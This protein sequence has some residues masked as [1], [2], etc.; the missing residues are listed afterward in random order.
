MASKKGSGSGYFGSTGGSSTT[1]TGGGGGG[2]G[3]NQNGGGGGGDPTGGGGGKKD[4]DKS[5]YT[6]AQFKATLRG[7]GLDPELFSHLIRQAVVNGWTPAE[8]KE[9]LYNSEEFSKSFPGIFDEKTG[10]LLLSPAEY[11]SARMDFK[12]AAAKYGFKLSDSD[13]GSY[14][15]QGNIDFQEFTDRIE[16]AARIKEDP[17]YRK[18]YE[19][20][21]KQ[22]GWDTSPGTLLD[23]IL[24]SGPKEFYDVL[25][26]TTIKGEARDAG[27]QLSDKLVGQI[28][29]RSGATITGENAQNFQELALKIKTT[30][31]LSRIYKFGITKSDLVELEFGGPH[32]ADIAAKVQRVVDTEKAFRETPRAHSSIQPTSG[33]TAGVAGQEAPRPQVY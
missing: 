23:S 15:V 14:V 33:G 6:N 32:Q 1:D 16:G 10:A 30:L 7:Y 17:F 24:G 9:K 26:K 4:P 28:Q 11:M 2:G 22:Y 13:F 21:A 12:R 8:F 27:V 5:R 29:K 20:Y 19:H 3:G 25:E 18:A 31:P